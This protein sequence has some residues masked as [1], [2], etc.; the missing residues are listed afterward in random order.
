M[1]EEIPPEGT[2]GEVDKIV[3][4]IEGSISDEDLE[5]TFLSLGLGH[6]ID[7]GRSNMINLLAWASYR[8][9]KNGTTPEQELLK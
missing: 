2:Q 8:S 9:I 4:D 3:T 6:L 5:Q 1:Q 7:L